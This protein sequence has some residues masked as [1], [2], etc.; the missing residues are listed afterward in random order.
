MKNLMEH[1][2]LRDM[3]TSVPLYKPP[4][5]TFP[6]AYVE[7]VETVETVERGH[8]KCFRLEVK[9]GIDF[10]VDETLLQRRDARD[11]VLAEVQRDM[12]HRLVNVIYGDMHRTLREAYHHARVAAAYGNGDGERVVELLGDLMNKLDAAHSGVPIDSYPR[13]R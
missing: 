9:I 10:K 5:T 3:R 6:T 8:Y 7:K 11:T 13:R 2:S 1:L 12:Q 4:M